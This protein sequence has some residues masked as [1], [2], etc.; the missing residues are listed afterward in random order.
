MQHYIVTSFITSRELGEKR[1]QMKT[2]D[3]KATVRTIGLAFLLAIGV[4]A[5]GG[6]GA[7]GGNPP[8]PSATAP[9]LVQQPAS[10]S[11]VDGGSATFSVTA[12]G[13]A[14]LTYQWQRNGR[15]IAGAT[16]PTLA[17]DHL[18]L[19][20]TGTQYRVLVT[21]SAGSVTSTSAVLTVTAAPI[22]IDLQPASVD[23]K[24]GATASLQVH[25]TGSGTLR[26]QWFRA[27]QPIAGATAVSLTVGPLRYGDDVD[28]TV[29]VS[30][31]WS[32]TLS[33][34]AAM[35]IQPN[36]DVH[37]VADCTDITSP[38][39]YSFSADIV[40]ASRTSACLYVHDTHDVQIDCAN[41]QLV[42]TDAFNAMQIERV[43]HFSLKNC[44]I[45]SS[46][47]FL[48]KSSWG[49]IA[50]NTL[51]SSSPTW[52]GMSV[53]AT[54]VDHIVFAHNTITGVYSERYADSGTISN[55]QIS[56]D[57]QKSAGAGIMTSI[58]RHARVFENTIDGRWN[59]QLSQLGFDDGIIIGDV[60]DAVLENNTISNVWDSGIEWVGSVNDSIIRDNNVT[61]AAIAAIGGWYWTSVSNVQFVRNKGTAVGR[62]FYIF[63]Y[64]GLRPARSDEQASLPAETEVR[65]R[66]NV[67]DGNL[68]IPK[69]GFSQ[70]ASTI[71]V[72]NKMNYT[73][74]L[75]N[76]VGERVI[77]DSAF[78]IGNNVF[79][80]NDFGGAN[81]LPPDFGSFDVVP[82]VVI[83]GGGNKCVNGWGPTYPL[84]CH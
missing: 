8:P 23:A 76:I 9:A 1:I 80:N 63:R 75:S 44:T 14:P 4:S 69:T 71:A 55:N 3:W 64:Y 15:D 45:N 77:P 43:D 67:F 38:G 60:S 5:C 82:G 34:A 78:N 47:F 73:D 37:Q 54:N 29:Q 72:F 42:G 81:A 68:V 50:N 41:H 49:S 24:D 27:G 32:S 7:G 12:T 22:T 33:S 83:D 35:R 18:A 70:Q 39:A 79:R 52:T 26:Y 46:W 58:S 11:V 57:P 36:A 28:Y 74:S 20:D 13:T 30:N 21:N 65:F 2:M 62:M 19:T 53:N 59:G 25:A 66:D 31:D 84:T 10:A 16:L 6:A 40:P 61:N 48:L 56:A 17:V 51:T